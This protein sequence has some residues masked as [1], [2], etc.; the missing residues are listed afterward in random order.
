MNN[1]LKLQHFA[2]QCYTT[3]NAIN[4]VCLINIVVLFEEAD[5]MLLCMEESFQKIPCRLAAA[6]LPGGPQKCINKE[7]WNEFN[8]IQFKYKNDKFK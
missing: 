1:Q 5:A 6:D 7:I 2:V 8:E 4:V 3:L